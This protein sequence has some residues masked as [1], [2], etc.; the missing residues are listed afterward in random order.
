[1]SARLSAWA[2]IVMGVVVIALLAAPA[3]TS[4]PRGWA[5]VGIVLCIVVVL[6]LEGPRWPRGGAKK[7]RA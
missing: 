6:V 2:Q 5:I 1:M 7:G 4:V 3:Y